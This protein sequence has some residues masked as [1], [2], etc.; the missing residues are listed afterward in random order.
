[1]V[2]GVLGR[3]FRR[4]LPI[5]ASITATLI[6]CLVLYGIVL[7]KNRTM[8]S[9]KLAGVYRIFAPVLK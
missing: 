9:V 7:W 6:L 3:P 4:A 2:Y 5:E 8:E 1:M